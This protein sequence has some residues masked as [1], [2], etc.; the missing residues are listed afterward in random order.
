MSGAA[1]DP[2]AADA[3]ADY[4]FTFACRRSGNCCAVPGGVVRVTADDVA[5]IAAHLGLSA[6]AVRS[7][8]VAASGDRLVDGFG[9]RCVFLAD[10]AEASCTI[11]PVRPQKCRDWPYWPELRDDPQLLAKAL[12]TCPGMTPR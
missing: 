8:Y 5:A 12:R 10:G 3:P 6:A 9:S 4:P 2:G 11:Y 1:G 7:R